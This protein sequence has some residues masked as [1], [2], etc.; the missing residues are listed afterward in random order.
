MKAVPESD[1]LACVTNGRV[2]LIDSATMRRRSSLFAQGITRIAVAPGG[3]MLAASVPSGDVDGARVVLLDLEHGEEIRSFQDPAL[4]QGET[5]TSGEL[6]LEFNPDGSLLM[7]ASTAEKG[8]KTVKLWEVA[9]GRMVTSIPPNGGHPDDTCF[10]PDGRLL[11]TLN[12]GTGVTLYELRGA[13]VQ[14]KI[15]HHAH[16]ISAMDCAADGRIIACATGLHNLSNR[17]GNPE[18]SLWEVATGRRTHQHTIP[19]KTDNDACTD[20][21]LHPRGTHLFSSWNSDRIL[22]TDVTE[23]FESR[24]IE[25]DDPVALAL[26]SE[27][28]TLWSAFGENI[29]TWSVPGLKK[30]QIWSNVT[31]RMF[32]GR[33]EIYCLAAGPGWVLAGMRDG[34]VVVFSASD[35]N[36]V[37]KRW[38]CSN[39]S[40]QSVALR[41]DGLVGAAAA[42]DGTV[43]LFRMPSGEWIAR[44]KRHG[45]SVDTIAFSPD[46]RLLATGSLDRSVRIW[47]VTDGSMN[48]LLELGP[49]TGPIHTVTFSPDGKSLLTVARGELAVRVWHLDRLRET[50]KPMGLDWE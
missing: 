31:A 13:S 9:S 32:T 11:V 30:K 47:R 25:A 50:L 6:D 5:H 23:R 16:P 34:S 20:L 22:V 41:P 4:L 19:R 1:K 36:H 8:D 28:A 40:L 12:D 26:N 49:Q 15:A 18:I 35:L 38:S 10:S 24:T 21:V 33:I 43:G 3:R 46:G 17:I 27:G 37:V 44:T 7:S 42:T 45:N 39:T 29:Q 14:T 2:E 48:E